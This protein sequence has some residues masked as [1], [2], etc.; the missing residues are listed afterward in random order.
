MARPRS[1]LV[2]KKIVEAAL[3]LMAERGMEAASM[4]AIAER[5]GVSKMTIY[6]HWPDKEALLLE[7]MAVLHG[8]RDRPAFDSGNTRADMIAVLAWSP[9]QQQA[10]LQQ[11]I[12]PDFMAYA[13]RNQKFGDAWRDVALEPPRRELT[14]LLKKAS[15]ARELQGMPSTDQCLSLLLGPMLYHRIFSGRGA[16]ETGKYARIVVDAFWRSFQPAN[17]T[18]DSLQKRKS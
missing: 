3:Q 11:R 4:D 12:W 9:I 7:A 5:A 2:H 6:N 1:P 17:T 18:G 10:E 13:A 14:R 16:A 15:A 8:L